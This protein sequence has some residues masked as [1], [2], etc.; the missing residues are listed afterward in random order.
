[1]WKSRRVRTVALVAAAA[2]V[3]IAGAMMA[4]GGDDPPVQVTFHDTVLPGPPDLS[5]TPDT[6]TTQQTTSSTGALSTTTTLRPAPA[7]PA[8]STSTSTSTT[9]SSPT[10]VPPLATPTPTFPGMPPADSEVAFTCSTVSVTIRAGQS[11][12][13]TCTATSVKGYFGSVSISCAADQGV[14]CSREPGFFELSAGATR[15]VSVQL[16][17]KQPLP[18]GGQKLNV[19]ISALARLQAPARTVSV[20]VQVPGVTL[21]CSPTDVTFSAYG[22]TVT[23][24][25]VTSGHGFSG[26]VTPTC[27]PSTG[28]YC[29]Y[30]S[31]SSVTVPEDGSATF[32][33]TLGR[34]PETTSGTYGFHVGFTDTAVMLITQHLIVP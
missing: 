25:T 23:D 2:V 22:P 11:G 21:A 1:M 14:V 4:T 13:V 16:E 18:P 29:A 3:L 5:D 15:T 31:P 32:R 30:F 27:W 19:N 12:T 10:S 34:A 9:F 17:P 20:S 26:T 24:C 7:H 33:V 28:I 6:T 8:T